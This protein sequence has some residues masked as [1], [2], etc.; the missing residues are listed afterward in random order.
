MLKDVQILRN[1]MKRIANNNQMI[2][3]HHF[4]L[5]ISAIKLE[6]WLEDQI[7]AGDR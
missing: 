4:L 3:E 2:P 7:E 1:E 6:V 5:D